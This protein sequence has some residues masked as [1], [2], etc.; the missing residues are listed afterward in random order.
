LLLNSS[1]YDKVIAFSKREWISSTKVSCKIIDF[2]KPETY[3]DFVQGD[4]FFSFDE[5]QAGRVKCV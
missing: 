2:D 5:Q 1:D 3:T 4:D